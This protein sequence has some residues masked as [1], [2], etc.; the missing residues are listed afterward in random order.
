MIRSTRA[1]FQLGKSSRLGSAVQ[2]GQR[3]TARRMASSFR[4]VEHT[5]TGCHTREYVA[6][7]ANGDADTPRLAV[8]QYIPLDNPTPK[9][10]D[11]TIIGAH[12]NGFPKVRDRG[13]ASPCFANS[14]EDN[15]NCMN[16]FGRRSI[17]GR[18]GLASASAPSS[19][20]TYGIRGSRVSS[21]KRFSETTVGDPS[22]TVLPQPLTGVTQRAGPTTRET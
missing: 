12:A 2:L 16:R 4:V 22:Y 6:A 9:P 7:T 13:P 18:L 19:S 17:G 3:Y 15:R 11:V 14:N 8:K 21:T 5:V 1:V 20:R 10:G